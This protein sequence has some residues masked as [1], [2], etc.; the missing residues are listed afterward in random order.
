MCSDEVKRVPYQVVNNGS[1][2][3]SV[4]I[5][6]RNLLG[7]EIS[8][9]KVKIIES[10]L[11]ENIQFRNLLVGHL[12]KFNRKRIT[13]ASISYVFKKILFLI[14]KPFSK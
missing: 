6:D 5:D 11:T 3:P 7:W 8:N 4:K 12:R 2:V 13:L 1:G 9:D 10:P 14:K